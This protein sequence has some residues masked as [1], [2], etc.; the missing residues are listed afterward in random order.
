MLVTSVLI[1]R[2]SLLCGFRRLPAVSI[3][4]IKLWVNQKKRGSSCSPRTC[5]L[6]IKADVSAVVF[7]LERDGFGATI[8]PSEGLLDRVSQG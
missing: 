5:I 6:E 4:G 3:G 1:A 2:R 7:F 8:R